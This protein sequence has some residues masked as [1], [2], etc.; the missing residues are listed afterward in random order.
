MEERALLDGKKTADACFLAGKWLDA[1]DGYSTCLADVDEYRANVA[2]NRNR[3]AASEAVW[4]LRKQLLLNLA[5][6]E[7]KLER[8]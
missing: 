3:A 2:N 7:A 4:E 1:L 6:V 5:A 8:W